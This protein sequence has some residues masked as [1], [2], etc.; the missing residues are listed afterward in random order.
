MKTFSAKA[1]M[2][3]LSAVVSVPLKIMV[4]AEMMQRSVN[5]AMVPF[6]KKMTQMKDVLFVKQKK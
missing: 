6:T 2:L 5:H 3:S 4:V 1:M